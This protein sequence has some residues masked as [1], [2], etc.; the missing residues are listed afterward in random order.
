V[1]TNLLVGLKIKI[2]LF[3]FFFL[4]GGGGGGW[5]GTV[6]LNNLVGLFLV[7]IFFYYLNTVLI[8]GL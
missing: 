5:G 8:V 7:F 1:P 3:L 2:A 4:G 6:G